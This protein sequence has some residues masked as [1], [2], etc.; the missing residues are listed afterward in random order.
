MVIG[1]GPTGSFLA[2]ALARRGHAVTVLDRDP[3]PAADGSWERPGV[4]QFR[5]PHAFRSQIAEALR[6]ELPGVL[7]ALVADGAY[8]A[9]GQM[10]VRRSVYEA[11]FRRAL[12]GEPGV[13]MLAGSARDIRTDAAGRPVLISDTGISTADLVLNATGRARF[14]KHRR[15]AG[16]DV[17]SGLAYVSREYQVA[18]GARDEFYAGARHIWNLPGYLVRVFPSDSNV[19]STLF[20]R[21]ADDRDL[22]VLRHPEA[23]EAATAAVPPLAALMTAD[24]VRPISRVYPGG[25]MRNIYRGQLTK[26]E[27]DTPG[28]IHVGDAV[29]SPSPMYGRGIATSLIQARALLELIDAGHDRDS[30]T[31]RFDA[32]CTGRMLPWFHDQVLDDAGVIGMWDGGD[33]EIDGRLPSATIT[34]AVA[35]EPRWRDVIGQYLDMRVL[36]SALAPVEVAARER[37]AA[38]WRPAFADGPDRQE[39]LRVIRGS[40]NRTS[41]VRPAFAARSAGSSGHKSPGTSGAA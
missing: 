30:V 24:K 11:V 31:R 39:L 13:T 18:P 9:E 32:W 3:G 19:I 17:D 12:S 26:D 20:V 37:I 34:R 25:A 23:Y 28:V 8:L 38:G 27:I 14:L 4:P 1:A 6:A 16:L 29:F 22:T 36:P 7:E 2:L 21:R 10:G 35:G 33:L 5:Q 41:P 40:V 15:T